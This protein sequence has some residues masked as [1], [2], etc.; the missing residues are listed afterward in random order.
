V[1]PV[2]KNK[3]NPSPPEKS[4]PK[5]NKTNHGEKHGLLT[6]FRKITPFKLCNSECLAYS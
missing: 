6:G 5:Q 2:S 4:L 1:R 3:T